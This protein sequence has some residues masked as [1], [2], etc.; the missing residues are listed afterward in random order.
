L[1]VL[2]REE[3]SRSQWVTRKT[4]LEERAQDWQSV[5][6]ANENI[7]LE[8][9]AYEKLEAAKWAPQE[10]FS[11]VIRRAQ[12]P[13]RP[14]TAAELLEE[15]KFRSGHSPLSDEALDRLAAAQENPRR[16]PSDWGEP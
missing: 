3:A 6:V 16:Q 1:Q 10:S 15:F 9:D 4:A 5:G 2:L 7:S 11:E 12:F 13:Q 8:L 14:H